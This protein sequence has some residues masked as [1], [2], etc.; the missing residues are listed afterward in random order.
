M[1][2]PSSSTRRATPRSASARPGPST[3]PAG[4][5]TLPTWSCPAPATTSTA[6]AGK[7]SRRSSTGS[8]A[9]CRTS[10]DRYRRVLDTAQYQILT[11]MWRYGDERSR[12]KA[13]EVMGRAST[14]VP[15]ADGGAP[16]AGPPGSPE[17]GVPAG[18]RLTREEKKAQT[19][20]RLIEAAARVFAEKGFAATSLDEVADAAGLTKGAVY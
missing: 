12:Q 16:Y 15:A 7:P 20:E 6:T 14:A 10:L 5:T 8:A 17:W 19:R 1:C 3:P 18:Q 13:G 4:P 9:G 2:R 11:G